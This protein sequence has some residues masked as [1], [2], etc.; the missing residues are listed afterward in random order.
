MPRGSD[1]EGEEKNP[2]QSEREKEN[3]NKEDLFS[4]SSLLTRMNSSNTNKMT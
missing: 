2:D 3:R 4:L 1:D